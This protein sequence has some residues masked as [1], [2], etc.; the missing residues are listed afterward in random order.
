[1]SPGGGRRSCAT[2]GSSV[3]S[4]SPKYD[5]ITVR[6]TA[7][8]PTARSMIEAPWTQAIWAAPWAE[9]RRRHFAVDLAC[10][11]ASD[12]RLAPSA[13]RFGRAGPEMAEIGQESA[14]PA[15]GWDLARFVKRLFLNRKPARPV[16]FGANLWFTLK[17]AADFWTPCCHGVTAFGLQ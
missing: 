2:R 5:H 12:I 13:C 10:A 9:W 3:K 8:K 7:P 15:P 17:P 16:G 14:L 6:R 4:H 11:Y 1:M